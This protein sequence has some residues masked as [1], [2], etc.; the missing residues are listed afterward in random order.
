MKFIISIT[1]LFISVC[2]FAQNNKFA[3]KFGQDNEF[4]KDTYGIGS[5]AN[6]KYNFGYISIF[7]NSKKL[8]AEQFELKSLNFKSETIIKLPDLSKNYTMEGDYAFDSNNYWIYSDWD[9]KAEKELLYAVNLGATATTGNVDIKLLMEN[10]RLAGV[11]RTTGGPSLIVYGK[12]K[13]RQDAAKK[14]LLVTY[15]IFPEDKNDKLRKDKIGHYVFDERM[16]KL[17]SGEF[18]M[19]YANGIM[20]NIDFS[21]DGKGNAYMLVKVYDS[22]ARSELNTTTGKAG[23]HL[24]ILKFTSDG[25][26]SPVVI[27]AG[28]YFVRET[29]FGENQDHKIVVSFTYTKAAKDL[30]LKGI[31]VATLDETVKLHTSKDGFRDFPQLL[32]DEKGSGSFTPTILLIRNLLFEK[33]GSILAVFEVYD[34]EKETTHRSS[35]MNNI[36]TYFH[37]ITYHYRDILA[38]KIGKDGNFEWTKT[39]PKKQYETY[40][41]GTLGFKLFSDAEGYYFLYTDDKRNTPLP[42]DEVPYKYQTGYAGQLVLSRID[43]AGNINKEVLLENKAE[44]M[45]ISLRNFT[46]QGTTNWY[47][48]SVLKNGNFKPFLMTMY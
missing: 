29:Y 24:E 6:D 20:D 8:Y 36:G 23:Y 26:M 5:W 43:K 35:S 18:Q 3:F 2:S 47:N 27:S 37:K 11:V 13:I 14:L 25:K 39:I 45:S 46:Q 1:V 40:Y 9:R 7:Q 10:P 34:V 15:K 31:F 21:I 28:E 44:D 17:W 22:E 33:D 32:P 30:L 42:K 19:P 41:S 38:Y 4:K 12:Y 16:N 48:F